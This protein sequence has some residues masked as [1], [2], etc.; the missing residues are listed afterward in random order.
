MKGSEILRDT[1]SDHQSAKY[2]AIWFSH[3]KDS[4]SNGKLYNE[5]VIGQCLLLESSLNYTADCNRFNG[6]GYI[7]QYNYTALHAAL[8]F[9]Q[10]AN[11]A[12]ARQ[13]SKNMD[14]IVE[15]TISPLPVTGVERSIGAGLNAFLAWFLVSARLFI[16]S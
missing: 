16:N 13:G 6:V 12:L 5:T 15:T 7:V 11:E 3:F 8:L 4:I 2:G 1:A 10:I 14:I 9:E